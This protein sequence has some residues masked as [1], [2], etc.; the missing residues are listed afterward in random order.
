MPRQ[1]PPRSHRARPGVR[2]TAATGRPG[3]PPLGLIGVVGYLAAL[4]VTAAGL[5]IAWHQGSD[6]GGRGAIVAGAALLVAAVVRLLLPRKLA[7]LLASRGRVSD[8][9]TLIVFGAGLLIAGVV[10]PR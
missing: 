4:T 7:G 10:L 8:A 3:D 9:A 6:G 2:G 1:A 5:Y